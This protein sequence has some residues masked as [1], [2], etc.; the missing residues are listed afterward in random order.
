MYAAVSL[1]LASSESEYP[2]AKSWLE[3]CRAEPGMNVGSKACHQN[4]NKFKMLQNTLEVPVK[5]EL[6][7]PEDR[8]YIADDLVLFIHS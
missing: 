2:V 4:L 8:H 6:P 5:S 1:T 7:A 3:I